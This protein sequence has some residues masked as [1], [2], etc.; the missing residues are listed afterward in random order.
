M[1]CT[2]WKMPQNQLRPYDK[3]KLKYRQ[4]IIYAYFLLKYLKN[5]LAMLEDI[6]NETI[7]KT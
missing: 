7:P 1:E 2:Y 4:S 6:L 3:Q 5:G